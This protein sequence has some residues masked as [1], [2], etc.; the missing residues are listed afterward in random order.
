MGRKGPPGGRDAW[1]D[2][3]GYESDP[4][5]GGTHHTVYDPDTNMRVSWNTDRDGNYRSGSGH[6]VDQTNNSKTQLDR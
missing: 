2:G 1:G 6:A 4:R 3:V 5:D